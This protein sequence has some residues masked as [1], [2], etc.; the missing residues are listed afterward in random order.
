LARFVSL[1]PLNHP[2]VA[3]AVNIVGR[4]RMIMLHILI[5]VLW[6]GLFSV[7]LVVP[8]RTSEIQ[9]PPGVFAAVVRAWRG[10]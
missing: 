9:G 4:I 1:S 2:L 10:G 6:D 8:S 5:I 7:S 3:V